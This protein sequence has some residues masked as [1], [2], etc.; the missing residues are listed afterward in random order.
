MMTTKEKALALFKGLCAVA[1]CALGWLAMAW[2]SPLPLVLAVALYL[3]VERMDHE[4]TG[5][6]NGK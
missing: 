2:D 6:N 5:G 4:I 3:V 1:C